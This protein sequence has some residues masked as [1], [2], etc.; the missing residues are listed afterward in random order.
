MFLRKRK[1]SGSVKNGWSR[2][3]GKDFRKTFRADFS[4]RMWRPILPL[5]SAMKMISGRL[6]VKKNFE[7]DPP[8][9][10][11]DCEQLDESLGM[12]LGCR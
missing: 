2:R 5:R 6:G 8:S 11:V 1:R 12:L 4:I 3:R 9:M 10:L 7:P